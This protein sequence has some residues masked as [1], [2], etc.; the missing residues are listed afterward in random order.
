MD[1]LPRGKHVILDCSGAFEA[2]GNDILKILEEKVDES[3]ARRVHSHVEIF[4][5]SI[6]PLG[7]AAIVLLDES[8]VS[9]H[10]YSEIGLLAIDIFC[11]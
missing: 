5:G 1:S 4:D 8:H 7:F 6:S 11:S 3:N 9:A 2:E 10:C